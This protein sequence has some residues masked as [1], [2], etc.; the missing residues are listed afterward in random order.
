MTRCAVFPTG[1]DHDREAPALRRVPAR[2]R[3]RNR[4]LLGDC[5]PA[6][7]ATGRDRRVVT[8]FLLVILC[9]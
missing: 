9:C 2:G 8:T 3:I 5:G 6:R 7:T 1:G 4:C